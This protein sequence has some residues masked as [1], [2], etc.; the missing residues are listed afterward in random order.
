MSALALAL[1]GCESPIGAVTATAT[2]VPEGLVSDRRLPARPWVPEFHSVPGK[3]GEPGYADRLTMGSAVMRAVS[4][5][6]A[7]KAA[8]VEVEAKHGEQAQAAVRPNPELL[9]EVENFGGTKS[10]KGFEAAEETLSITQ[11]FEL[12]DKRLKRLRAA[13]LESSLAGWDYE[14]VRLQTALQAAQAFVDVLSAQERISVLKNFV[15]L[16]ERTHRTVEARISA[17]KASPIEQDRSSV[18]L[19]RAR[20]LV[21]TEQVRLEEAKRRLAALWGAEL[22]S[23]GRAEGRLDRTR[24][25]PSLE[26]LRSYL[27]NNPS[28]ARWSDG[29]GHR[30]AVLDL[31]RSKGIRDIRVGAGVRRLNDE[32]S[33]ALVATVSVP[34]QLFDRNAGAIAA[35]ERRVLKAEHEQQSARVQVFGTLIEALGSLKVAATQAAALERDVLPFAEQA[36]ERT[37]I[38]FNEGRFDILNVL[39]AQRSVFEA[40]LERVNAQADYAKARVQIEALIGRDLNG[41]R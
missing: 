4:Y 25:V 6:P 38:G 13:N 14:A 31:E 28:L 41:L 10:N 11:T 22:K 21:R 23:F 7:I 8:F 35:A 30:L 9:L 18:A 3:D 15:T 39:D 29:V 2:V 12:G 20:V 16:A 33:T 1:A 26:A 24:L 36:F 34:L 5:N 19:A 40:R 17:G 32:E 37:Q 27:D